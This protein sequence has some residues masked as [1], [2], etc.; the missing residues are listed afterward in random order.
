[1]EQQ[2][3]RAVFFDLDGTLLPMELE[4]FMKGYFGSLTAFMA[5][6]G[7]NPEIFVEALNAGVRAMA[8]NQGACTNAD[9][10]WDAFFTFFGRDDFAWTEIFTDFYENEFGK[11]GSAAC[12]DPDAARAVATLRAKGYPLVLATMP[13][14]PRR[15]VEWRLA[16]A[17]IDA[18]HF[19]RITDYENST[20]VKPFLVYFEQNLAAAGLAADEVLMVGNNTRED[21]ACLELGFDAYLVTDN[22]IDPVSFDLAT[23]KHGSMAE[24]AQWVEELPEC[25]NPAT[26]IATGLVEA[27]EAAATDAAAVTAN[28]AASDPKTNERA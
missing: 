16:W 10:F 17:G 21:L 3:Y 7:V 2:R 11:L 25:S 6:H 14:F 4:S 22:L 26:C 5:A 9:A 8:K 27:A 19:E 15:A 28:P 12:A 24:F 20:S 18:A 1:M 23:V 13:M